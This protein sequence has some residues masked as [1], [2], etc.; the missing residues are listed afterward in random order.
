MFHPH[1]AAGCHHH[2]CVSL[3]GQLM[4]DEPLPHCPAGL[5]GGQ[6]LDGVSRQQQLTHHVS[7]V[8]PGGGL[9]GC[10]Y[11]RRRLL[12]GGGPT[13]VLEV[14][15]D[16]ELEPATAECSGACVCLLAQ[17]CTQWPALP[18]LRG[19]QLVQRTRYVLIVICGGAQVVWCSAACVCVGAT[20]HVG[21]AV[22]RLQWTGCV[23]LV[24]L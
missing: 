2:G 11:G 7:T 21:V 23:K 6:L 18:A 9:L 17:Q 13:A 3:V 16:A 8:F 5:V 20:G 24:T 1:R 10:T 4:Y 14:A 19:V 12:R 15:L 22:R